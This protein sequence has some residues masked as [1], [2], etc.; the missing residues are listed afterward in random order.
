MS[1][2]QQNLQPH[3]PL[4]KKGFKSKAP[5]YEIVNAILYKLKKGVQWSYLSVQALFS[6]QVFGHFRNWC[7]VGVWQSCWTE[8]LKKNKSLIDLSSA[9]LDGSHTT[10][11]RGG[12]QVAYQGRKN[13]K[14]RILYIL[15]IVK[16]CH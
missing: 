14:Q 4:P 10:A 5:I 8:L 7:K 3:L 2:N 11:L 12:E 9:D 16:V 13:V 15:Q 6:T 1:L